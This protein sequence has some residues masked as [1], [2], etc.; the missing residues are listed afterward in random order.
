[1]MHMVSNNSIGRLCN[2]D[3]TELPG[4]SVVC[5]LSM[6]SARQHLRVDFVVNL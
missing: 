4:D 2:P 3:S 1:M 6:F 5:R